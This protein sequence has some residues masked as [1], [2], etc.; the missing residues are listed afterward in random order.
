MDGELLADQPL[1]QKLIK[2]GFW[3]YF[4]AYLIGPAW[5][6]VRVIVSNSVSVADVGILYTV[7]WLIGLLNVYNDLWL[8]ESLQ[9]FLPRYRLNKQYN[10]IKTSIYLSL[11][12]Q[13]FTAIIIAI[14]LRLGA[15]RLADHYFHSEQAVIIL[16][17]FCFY[18]L[19]IN[20]FQVLQNIFIAFQDTLSSQLMDF[21]RMRS[22]VG[23]TILF[24]F[25]GKQSI[26]R[27][28]INRILWLFA[29]IIIASIIFY[30]KYRKQLFQWKIVFEKPMIKEYI[31]YALWC[32]LSLNVAS[33]FWQAI[34]QIT[35]VII[36][37][38]A[39]WY[40]TNFLSLFGIAAIIIWPIMGVI[41]P[42]V[43]ELVSKKDIKKLSLLFNFF[44]TYFSIF[45][46]SLAVFFM[47]LG[48]ELALILFGQKFILSGTL[49]SRSAIGI[50]FNILLWFNFGVLAGLGKIKER[51][52]ILVITTIVTIII[53]IWTIPV[54]WIYWA[55]L[56]FNIS[57]LLL[58]ILS[59]RILN[60][61][62]KIYVHPWF[63]IKNIFFISILWS[64]IW[65][66][67]WSVFI[68]DD[69]LRYSNFIKM[70]VLW[71]CFYIVFAIFNYKKVIEL[72]KEIKNIKRG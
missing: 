18:F 53:T 10:Y 7:L 51:V 52:K 46:L 3:L 25:T 36:W 5:Y 4:F 9:Y 39:A 65:Y 54:L 32:F 56:W 67:K 49:L 70:I 66:I 42:I 57:Q 24:F 61:T 13:I 1:G 21:I 27:Y 69:L 15:P 68:A 48:P 29:W 55:I 8:T 41:F 22:V 63:I 59:Y 43:S 34:Q 35:I 23:F 14:F 19:G 47:V 31:K 72:K 45:S 44:Y 58:F 20:L 71:T 38:D 2:K 12:V 11:T 28:S 64:I 62:T 40:Y 60:K 37:P 6:L 30:K 33:L 17:Y 16:K 26:E 50:V